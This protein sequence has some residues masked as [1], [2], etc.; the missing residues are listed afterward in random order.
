MSHL[1]SYFQLLPG[2][3]SP[4][5]TEYLNINAGNTYHDFLGSF[6]R[7]EDQFL[8]GLFKQNSTTIRVSPSITL[9]DLFSLK[10]LV[11]PFLESAALLDAFTASQVRQLIWLENY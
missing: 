3:V 7:E 8:S 9:L 11:M 6:S 2:S 5:G 1:V 4:S 10:L